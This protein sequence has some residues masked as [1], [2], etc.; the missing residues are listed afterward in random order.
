MF[1]EFSKNPLWNNTC[2]FSMDAV[3][4]SLNPVWMENIFE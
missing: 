1:I 4:F 2:G 3:Q